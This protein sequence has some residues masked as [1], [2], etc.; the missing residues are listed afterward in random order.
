MQS[1]LKNLN[2]QN[3][4]QPL[5][6]LRLCS[7]HFSEECF[8]RKNGTVQLQQGSIPTLFHTPQQQSKC[9]YCNKPKTGEGNRTFHK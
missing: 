7:E 4:K 5:E 9:I 8:T 3:N 6:H 2:L 1:W